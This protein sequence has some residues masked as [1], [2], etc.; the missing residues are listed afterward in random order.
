SDLGVRV[1]AADVDIALLG[2]HGHSGNGEGFDHGEGV[3]LHHRPILERARLGLVGVADHIAGSGLAAG[4]VPLDAGGKGS[5]APA[6]QVGRRDLL[7]PRLRASP[8]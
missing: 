2:T 5:P 8:E 3:A 1:L 7:Y 4:S 6:A